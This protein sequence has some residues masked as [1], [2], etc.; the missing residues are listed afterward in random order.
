ML[1][2]DLVDKIEEWYLEAD[3]VAQREQQRLKENF[4]MYMGG[5]GQWDEDT[6]VTLDQEGRPHLSINK[7]MSTVNTISGL[8]RKFRENME[9]VPRVG[10]ARQLARAYTYMCR[11]ALDTSRPKADFV[12]SEMFMMGAIGGKWWAGLGT[13]RTAD[14]VYGDLRC[15]SLPY[16]KVLEDPTYMGYSINQNDPE[17]YCR[18]MFTIHYLTLPQILRLWPNAEERI[19][20]GGGYLAEMEPSS[21]DVLIGPSNRSSYAADYDDHY[22]KTASRITGGSRHLTRRY[23]VKRCWWKTWERRYIVN[24]I[25]SG[26]QWD[27]TG[28]DKA[29]AI[30]FTKSSPDFEFIP[31]LVPR[32]KRTEVLDTVLLSHKNDPRGESSN[33]PLV[34]FSPYWIFGTHGGLGVIDNIKD[35][36]RELNKRRSQF[37]HILNSSA[38]SGILV[39]EDSLVEES[40]WK[41]NMSKPGFM[42]FYAKGAD[43]P[44]FIT[45]PELSQG[46]ILAAKEGENDFE[47]NT[48]VNAGMRGDSPVGESGEAMKVRRDQGMLT[49][50]PVFDNFRTSQQELYELT[51]EEIRRRDEH[52]RGLYSDEEL[53]CVLEE[54]ELDPALAEAMAGDFGRYSTKVTSQSA[55][56]T[57]RMAEFYEMVDLLKLTPN[58]AVEADV[59][60]L[61]ASDNA[62]V[63]E[64]ADKIEQRRREMA[65]QRRQEG[66]IVG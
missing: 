22:S 62:R 34:R 40:N 48:N 61:R 53:S 14:P 17:D 30:A 39:E 6:I 54:N 57:V 19:R 59:D 31:W 27:V 43:K 13:D 8:Q 32:L 28:K 65:Q 44:T 26:E 20:A 56:P 41:N 50:E 5:D 60:I 2:K 58:L 21:G 24:H 10:G 16:F 51:L 36:Q 45:P 29:S 25:P 42:G 52:G 15:L 7:C 49:G 23:R 9:V 11:H 35:A 4:L 37:L 55:N 38:N 18:Y 64:L 47:K 1:D 12:L 63:N 3:D 33:Y 66:M 46:H